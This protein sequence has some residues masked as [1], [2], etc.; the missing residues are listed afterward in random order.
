MN[1]D[2]MKSHASVI[3][4]TFQNTETTNARNYEGSVQNS[5]RN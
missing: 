3:G 1:L 4:L 5:K 2:L